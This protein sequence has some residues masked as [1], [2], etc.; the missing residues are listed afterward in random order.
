MWSRSHSS[1]DLV[2]FRSAAN[3]CHAVIIKTKRDYNSKFI[4]SAAANPR[5]LW[6]TVN[7]FLHRNSSQVL[8]SHE[9]LKSLSQSVAT[10]FS[11]KILKLHTNLLSKAKHISLHSDPPSHPVNLSNF[12]LLTSFLNCYLSL[13][14]LLKQCVSVLL[15]I[16]TITDIIN[17]SFI[18]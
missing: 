2:R 5:K 7:N 17:L 14:S 16:P 8:P 1:Y 15:P 18:F 9:C 6:T 11:D 3:H 4:F 12:Q 10:F 13:T